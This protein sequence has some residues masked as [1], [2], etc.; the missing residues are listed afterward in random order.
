MKFASENPS[1]L[2]LDR[3]VLICTVEGNLRMED[4]KEIL[5]SM[6]ID[7]Y[8]PN[9]VAA[10]HEYARSKIFIQLFSWLISITDTYF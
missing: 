10:I 7:S 6:G 1:S 8:D 9:V 2:D 3:F 5:Q 4:I